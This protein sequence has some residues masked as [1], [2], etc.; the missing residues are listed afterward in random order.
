MDAY[1]AL[2]RLYPASFRAE[3]GDEMRAVFDQ[4]RREAGGGLAAARL[5][6]EA[7]GD[8]A[9]N[10]L[11][12]HADLL[13]QDLRYTA[14]TLRRAPGF[15]AT[16]VTVAALGIAATTA[17]FSITDHV[18]I[19]PLPFAE[20]DRLC[21]LW[22]DQSPGGYSR[23]EVSP[24]NY[25]D[26]KAMSGSFDAM[27][28]YR[29]LSMSL[30]G[31]GDPEQLEAVSATAELF[32]I[33]G[34]SP[35]LGRWFAEADAREGAPG[36]ALLSHHLWTARFAS[37][38]GVIGRSLLLNGEPHT[39]IGVMPADFR[40]PS[41]ETEVWTA[42]RFAEGDFQDRT[43]TYIYVVARRKAGL[44]AGAAQAEMRV[45]AAQLERAHPDENAKVTAT[46]VSLRDQISSQARLLLKAL[47]G[48]ALCV[49]LIACTNLAGLLIARGAFRRSELAVRTALGAGRERLVRQLMTESLVLAAAGGALGVALAGAVVPLVTRLVPNALPIA[50]VPPL[51]LRVLGF[52]ALVTIVTGLTFGVVPAL[53][54]S[55]TDAAEGLRDGVR[56]G[57]PSERLRALLVTAE[58]TASVV[59]LVGAGLLIRALWNVQHVDPGLRTEGVL[60][61]RTT[62][63]LP[64]YA[65]VQA[66][67]DFYTRVVDEVRALPGVTQAA[68]ITGLPM[69]MRGGIWSVDVPGQPSEPGRGHPVSLR[70]VTP[71]LFDALGIPLRAGRDVRLSDTNDEAFVAVVSASLVE[72]HWPGQE[73]V[74]RTFTVAG[75]A[76]TVVGVVGDVRVRGLERASEPQV[77]LPHQ[78]VADASMQF[79]SPRELVVRSSG[80]PAALAPAVRR[81]VTRVDPQ[82]PVSN[83]QT[84]AEV[85]ASDTAP[86]SVQVRVLAGFAALALL[87]A[88]IG[89]H[90]LLAFTVSHRQLEFGVRVALG[91]RPA[92]ILRLVLGQGV[93]LA[94]M[95]VAAGLGLAWGMGRGLQALLAGVSPRDPLVFGAAAALAL[96]MTAPGSVWPAVRAARVD[97][98]AIMRAE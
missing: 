18:L 8:V 50:A 61:L 69:V 62:L 46:V 97:P 30:V 25:R 75:R 3:Y 52:A 57:T 47:F 63:P 26:W 76:R 82:Q 21:A 16:A 83:V 37:D 44:S 89:I 35:L 1:R 55:R 7:A 31:G 53:R 92:D 10:A 68:Y 51:D 11:R 84:L 45:V 72:R 39:V 14:R 94:A 90:G 65:G 42:L 98:R 88:G 80:D 24:A 9:F 95:G 13:G 17:T 23:N 43:D 78:Q 64:K 22:Q 56:A 48:A 12:V 79:Y 41:R 67:H 38:P 74:G 28:A 54:A 27:A 5:W 87:L 66:R 15:A 40:F 93:A 19:R 85:V 70:F 96:L 77:Y 60:T 81:I 4:R 20:P 33:L 36:T 91:A 32:P 2:L 34:R 73:A 49:L 58:V 71:G 86:R 29:R 59:L 6:L